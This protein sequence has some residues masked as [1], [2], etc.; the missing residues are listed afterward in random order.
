MKTILV[1]TDFSKEAGHAYA[2]ALELA[3][4]S[5]ASVH[6]YHVIEYYSRMGVDPMEF[7]V[8][9]PQDLNFLDA[10]TASSKKKL[11]KLKAKAPEH[12]KVKTA[13]ELG[14]PHMMIRDYIVEHE[15]D[16]VIMG[17][18]GVSGLEG[19]IFGSTAEKV[20]RFSP[21]P[22]LVLSKKTSLSHLKN[23]VLGFDFR[24]NPLDMVKHLKAF[25]KLVGGHIYVVWVN[26]PNGFKR[27]MLI[28]TSLKA[29]AKKYALENYSLHV[30]SDLNPE[31]GLIEFA[32]MM[33]ADMLATGTHQR[34][35]LD[36]LVAGSITER[37]ISKSKW[38]I[39]TCKIEG[40]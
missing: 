36:R 1:P 32:E 25:Q 33:K 9:I 35:G 21:S 23:I 8:A 11:T 30:F 26:T 20:V 27:E 40:D 5:G 10:F 39:W 7:G 18:R 15:V 24:D 3:E 22:V 16:L 12:I 28:H 4:R 34:R 19:M 29:F 37:V 14:A 17:S 6:L 38:P 13:F 2:L 31:Q